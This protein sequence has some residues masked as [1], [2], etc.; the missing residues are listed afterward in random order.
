MSQACNIIAL[1]VAR[2]KQYIAPEQPATIT[3]ISDFLKQPPV[4]TLQGAKQRLCQQLPPK[5]DFSGMGEWQTVAAVIEWERKR[6]HVYDTVM[7]G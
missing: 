4:T 7:F 3:N 6:L 1:P 2:S 5:P